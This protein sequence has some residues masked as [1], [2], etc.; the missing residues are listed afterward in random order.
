[1]KSDSG[2]SKDDNADKARLAKREIRTCSVCGNEVSG[3]T[4][5]GA[6][7]PVCILRG[8]LS[9]GESAVAKDG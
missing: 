9:A 6:A 3:T 4:T 8:S 2:A 5:K 7:C 1:M